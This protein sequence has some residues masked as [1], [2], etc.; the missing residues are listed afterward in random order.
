MFLNREGFTRE[1]AFVH[2]GRAIEHH[3]V[4]GN[5]RAGTHKHNVANDNLVKR[6]GELRAVFD[7]NR[8]LRAQVHEFFNR[9]GGL[10]F[11][12]GF[13]V[14]AEHHER[15][16]HRSGLKIEMLREAEIAQID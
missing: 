10:A 14:F 8:S 11:A 15:D 5:R 7:D 2:A 3:A 1:H 13:E 12:D 4:D 16:N 9:V 6:D